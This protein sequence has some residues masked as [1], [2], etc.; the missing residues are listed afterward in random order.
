MAS[1]GGDEFSIGCERGGK[2]R[3]PVVERGVHDRRGHVHI[4]KAELADGG[5]FGRARVAYPAKRRRPDG[6]ERP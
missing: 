3:Q 1:S 5:D 6:S 2:M 4:G